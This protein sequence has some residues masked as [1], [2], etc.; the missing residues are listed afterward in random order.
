MVRDED[1]EEHRGQE[2][3]K[4]TGNHTTRVTIEPL[5]EKHFPAARQ[6]ENEFIGTGKGFCFGIL[7]YR[8]CPLSKEEFER[9]Y[10]QS[11]DNRC[12]T[13][14]V[15]IRE[16]DRHVI[17]IC[18][19]RIKDQPNTWD[20]N[21]IHTIT[22]DSECYLD[23]MA[24]TKEGRGKG[25][26]TKLMAWADDVASDHQKTKMTLGVFKGNPAIR[27]YERQG[28]QVVRNGSIVAPFLIGCPHGQCGTVFMEKYL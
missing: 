14:G 22:D 6:I 5:S 2:D 19:L 20:E 9:I 10:R 11:P 21:C 12:K 3:K 23:S 7:P 25:V 26:G 18:K 1:D 13:Y 4:S 24:V 15:A 8:L 17:G 27:L 28:Y 16:E